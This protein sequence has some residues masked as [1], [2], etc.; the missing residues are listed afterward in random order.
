MVYHSFVPECAVWPDTCLLNSENSGNH[1]PMKLWSSLCSAAFSGALCLM[2]LARPAS[3]DIEDPQAYS[4]EVISQGMRS[5]TGDT[6]SQ[7]MMA[8][9]GP[10]AGE[11]YSQ[12]MMMS[13][14]D[15]YSQGME[16]VTP[17]GDS[18]GCAGTAANCTN[19]VT[20]TPTVSEPPANQPTNLG[21]PPI[22]V[23]ATAN[24]DPIPEPASFALLAPA[25]LWL[26]LMWRR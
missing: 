14:G 25:L 17:G 23:I 2:M 16:I 8:D 9:S 6:F 26:G 18:Q 21:S 5:A 13:T 4:S 24:A 3:A 10:W 11:I 12:G 20:N 1:M 7:G 15:I 22:G 19:N